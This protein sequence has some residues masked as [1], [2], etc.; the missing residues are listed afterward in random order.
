MY[1]Y[2]NDTFV[3]NSS[4]SLVLVFM[5]SISFSYCA[6]YRV[7]ATKAPSNPLMIIQLT[8]SVFNAVRDAFSI[9]YACFSIQRYRRWL[10]RAV[11]NIATRFSRH[12]A[13][14]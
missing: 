5:G 8:D 7:E 12:V 13:L 6:L 10:L 4:S 9:P 11:F 14:M 2:T 1:T 3:L